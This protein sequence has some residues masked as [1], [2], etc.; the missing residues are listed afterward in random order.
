MRSKG[1]HL[2]LPEISHS[3][4][5]VEAGCGHF[6]VLPW[7]GH[8]L[9]GTTDTEFLRR[10]RH[11]GGERKRYRGFPRHLPEYLPAAPLNA[12][13]WS[14]SMPVCGRWWMMA[15]GQPTMPAAAPNWWTMARMAAGWF[16]FR[17][18]RQMDHLA[19]SG[20]N[21]HRCGGAQLEFKAPPCAT[22]ITPLPGGR[23]DVSRSW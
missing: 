6:F 13:R 17:A 11:R 10:S 19:Q 14:S 23:F 12:N 4:L 16:V 7:R 9:L 8:T 2:L 5:T 22:A 18:G 3:A 20:G 15:P 1:I 21:H